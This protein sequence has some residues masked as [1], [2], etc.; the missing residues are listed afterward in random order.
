ME[1]FI[2]ITL[3]NNN[4]LV[5]TKIHEYFKYKCKKLNIFFKFT[6]RVTNNAHLIFFLVQV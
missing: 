5:T 2:K 4:F 1:S 3:L 6:V